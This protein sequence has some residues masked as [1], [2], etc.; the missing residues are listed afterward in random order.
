MSVLPFA[1]TNDMS[2]QT[3]S[4]RSGSL[5]AE[6]ALTAPVGGRLTAALRWGQERID[7]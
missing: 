7:V 4:L 5:F 2:N 3:T 1:P 6:L